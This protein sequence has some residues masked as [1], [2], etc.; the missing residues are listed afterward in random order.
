MEK[1]QGNLFSTKEL[2]RMAHNARGNS[3][4][5]R[6]IPEKN[7]RKIMDANMHLMQGMEFEN[8][9]PVLKPYTGPT[10]FSIVSYVDRNKNRGKGQALH[11]FLDDYRFRDPLW[12][13]LSY[14]TYS[15]SNYDYVFTPDFSL[16]R[17]LRTDFPNM[18]NTYRTRFVGAY[19]QICG[20]NVIPTASWGGLNSFS[21]CFNGLPY[22][23]VIAVSGMG[24]RKDV[25]SFQR[26]CYGLRR[27]EEARHPS[28]ILI[29]GEEVE[30]P[31]LITPVQFLPCYISKHFRNG[32]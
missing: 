5:L 4:L 3:N 24:V 13:N 1:I 30:I 23:G 26:W 7:R 29:Y 14:T 21:F 15:I 22:G 32:K 20:F 6:L 19:W 27:L 31:S 25:Y 16:W 28:L 9:F 11:F 8:G 10:D 12:F 2:Y 17:N 18:E